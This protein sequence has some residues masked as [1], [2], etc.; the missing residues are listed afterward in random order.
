M[1]DIPWRSISWV[2]VIF[3]LLF[4]G[5][6]QWK[7]N[8]H[9]PVK[10]AAAL[11]DAAAIAKEKAQV[12]AAEESM[13]K[14]DVQSSRYWNNLEL[15][16]ARQD[17]PGFYRELEQKL[18]LFLTQQLSLPA[19]ELN[20]QNMAEKLRSRHVPQYN[21]EQMHTLL[22]ECELAL[23]TPVVSESE[24]RTTLS[25]AKDLLKELQIQLA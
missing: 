12:A 18:W 6:Y 15:K 5:F 21:I 23:Y 14:P 16:L 10:P 24:L 22:G 1:Q 8:R 25:K 19:T 4:L 17:A 20:K 11:P 3:L 2:A 9:K 13:K 7:Q